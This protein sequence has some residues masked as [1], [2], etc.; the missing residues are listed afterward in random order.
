M[1]CYKHN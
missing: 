1:K